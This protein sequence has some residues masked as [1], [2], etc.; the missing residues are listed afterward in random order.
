[1]SMPRMK[2]WFPALL[3][4]SGLMRGEIVATLERIPGWIK[5]ENGLI[6]SW[7]VNSTDASSTQITIYDNQ[8]HR[9]AAFNVLH[10]IE[11][12][13]GVSIYDV[14]VQ[15][16]RMIAVAATY[17]KGPSTS[18]ASALLYFDFSGNLLSVFA[19]DAQ[20]EIMRLAV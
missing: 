9:L 10:F 13:T 12:A 5:C 18:P 4:V 17:S 20:H 6:V 19:L 11:E 14:S 15:P 2:T 8:G 3:L 16:K 7:I 1:M